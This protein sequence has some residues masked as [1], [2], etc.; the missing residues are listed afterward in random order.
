V[1]LQNELHEY[2]TKELL[3]STDVVVSEDSRLIQDGLINSIGIMK[4]ITLLSNRFGMQFE[5]D[6]YKLEN[7]ETLGTICRLVERRSV[8]RI[9]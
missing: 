9:A 1:A 7:F 3:R 6:D 8:A 5:D 2:I 4:L